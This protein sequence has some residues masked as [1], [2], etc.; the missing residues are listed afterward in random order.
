MDEVEASVTENVNVPTKANDENVA[1]EEKPEVPRKRKTHRLKQRFTVVRKLGQ[2][3]YGKVQLA[4]NNES[5]LEV[6]VYLFPCNVVFGR[7]PDYQ[8]KLFSIFL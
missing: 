5:G 3:T 4:I 8:S 2:G 7:T 6:S 1:P